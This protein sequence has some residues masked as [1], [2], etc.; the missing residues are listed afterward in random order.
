MGKEI[1][2][3][4]LEAQIHQVKSLTTDN[5]WHIVLN[6]PEYCLPQVQVVMGWLKGQVR[7]VIEIQ[8]QTNDRPTKTKRY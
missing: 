1:K 4:E 2:A 6:V 3:V 8:D 7:A 5:T